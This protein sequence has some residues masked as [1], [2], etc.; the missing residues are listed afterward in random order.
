MFHFHKWRKWGQVVDTDN[1][2]YKAQFSSCAM[3]EE[4]RVR[5]LS[6]RTTSPCHV[7]AKLI[8]E[9]VKEAA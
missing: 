7:P 5:F 3:C 6:L 4:V 9:C 2:I 1:H 8:N